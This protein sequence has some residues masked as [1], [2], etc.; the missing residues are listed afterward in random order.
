MEGREPVEVARVHGPVEAELVRALLESYGITVAVSA[1]VPHSVWPFTVDGPG[2]VG[3]L[4]AREDE[5]AA[6]DLLARHRQAG[7]SMIKHADPAVEPES[8][9]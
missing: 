7:F 1:L 2:R 6:T 5:P 9:N 8:E 4:V 3:I